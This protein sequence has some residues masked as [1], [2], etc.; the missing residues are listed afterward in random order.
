M[1]NLMTS[2]NRHGKMMLMFYVSTKS[3]ELG[4]RSRISPKT[5]RPSGAT[6]E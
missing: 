3:P 4:D 2:G 5:P 6:L 1:R